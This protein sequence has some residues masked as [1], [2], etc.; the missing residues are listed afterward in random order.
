MHNIEANIKKAFLNTNYMVYATKHKQDDIT[1]K[2]GSL[3]EALYGA[4]PN[5]STWAYLTAWNPL[6]QVLSLEQNRERNNDLK[7]MLEVSHIAFTE[8]IGVS[9]D[10]MWSEESFLI[11]NIDEDRAY[12]LAVKFGQL[13]FVYGVQNQKAKL[14]FTKK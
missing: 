5:L 4:I 7:K 6:P 1:I 14:V 13:A 11:Q 9:E 8:G 3:N 2:I 12:D 10:G